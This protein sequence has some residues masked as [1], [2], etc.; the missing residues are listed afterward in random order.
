METQREILL[1]V[2]LNKYISITFQFHSMGPLLLAYCR[3]LDYSPRASSKTCDYQNK[4]YLYLNEYWSG[5]CLYCYC[6]FFFV[7][8][9]VKVWFSF[10]L[11]NPLPLLPPLLFPI[12]LLFSPIF[13]SYFLFFPPFFSPF[14]FPFPFS[15]SLSLSLSPFLLK[16][17][18]NKIKM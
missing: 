9:I 7:K 18:Q 14:C 2:L 8:Y 13:F 1:E 3:C 15:I 11:S 10:L 12:F 6:A 17:K 16:T 4:S 5:F